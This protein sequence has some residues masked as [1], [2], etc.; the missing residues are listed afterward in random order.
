MVEP[1][2]K[3]PWRTNQDGSQHKQPQGEVNAPPRQNRDG[4]MHC[5]L[6][7]HSSGDCKRKKAC[8]I[9]GLHNHSTYDCRREPLWNFGPELCAA[10]VQDQSFFS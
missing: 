10:Q 9:C 6:K 4:C 5:G 3:Q 8:E 7:N 2:G 1:Q